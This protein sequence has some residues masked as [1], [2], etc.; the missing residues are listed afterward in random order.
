MN[1]KKIL[2]FLL[3]LACAA[4]AAFYMTRSSSVPETEQ[5]Y[6][7]YLPADTMA[8]IS[9]LDL[10]GL[11]DRFPTTSLGKFLA[12]PTIHGILNELSAGPDAVEEYDRI[13]DG[14]SGVLTNPAFRQ[15]F[16][17]DA[18]VAVLPVD[19]DL[20]Q[21]EPEQ[22]MRKAVLVFGTSS[23]SGAMDGFAR[24][25]MGKN[26]TREKVDGLE[27]TR[28]QLDNGEAV[29]GYS[30]EGVLLLAYDPGCITAAVKRR[31]EGSTLRQFNAFDSAV[32]Y[33]DQAGEGHQ[34]GRIY[35]NF[36]QIAR[37]LAASQDEDS[38]EVAQYFQG[39]EAMASVIFERDRELHFSSRM[40]YDYEALNPLVK[41][42]YQAVSDEELTLGLLTPETLVY[43]W[44]S[45]IDREY[46]KGLI[47]ATDDEQFKKADAR[48]EQ[49][50]GVSLDKAIGAVGPQT[51]MVI[52]DIVN[53][54]MF[55]L[56]KLVLFLQ[57]RDRE[58]V[59]ILLQRLRRDIAEREFAEEQ[60]EEINGRTVYFWPIL[61]GEATQ[62]AIVA[63]DNMIY[64]SNSKQ[65]LI[66]L[67]KREGEL[68]SLSMPM[69]DILGSSIVENIGAGNYAA[70][71]MRPDQLATKVKDAADWLAGI[72]SA[73]N[74]VSADRLKEEVLKLMHSV[75][76]LV[77]TSEI[78][79]KQALSSLVLRYK[80]VDG[81]KSR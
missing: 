32:S 31:Q 73:A 77:G 63:T 28:V 25:V 75:D 80:Q 47:A 72:L 70:F 10:K 45:L 66:D 53:T 48:F 22:E 56:P 50:L 58:T 59:E 8:T 68:K 30:H 35:V 16:G 2:L 61:P 69:A 38:Q 52:S 37:L 1:I 54:G 14:I 3:I 39:F 55:P 64:V 7:G 44:V 15:V 78:G 27:L 49:E 71:V 29:Y 79:K 34:Y 42:Q 67:V 23:V 76:V 74:D 43:Y 60:S 20:L 41:K 36:E 24:L 18:V 26:V 5:Y 65:T 57:I 4:G 17:D 9:L 13:F 19:I 33:W 6:A 62:P 40:S 12:K 51:G 21:S 81:E 46:I 11:T